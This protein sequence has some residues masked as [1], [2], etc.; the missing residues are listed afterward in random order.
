MSWLNDHMVALQP[1][2]MKQRA[3]GEDVLYFCLHGDKIFP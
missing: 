1:D 3:Q 2:I